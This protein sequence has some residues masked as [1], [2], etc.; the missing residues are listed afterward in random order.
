MGSYRDSI[1]GIG[2]IVKGSS[3]GQTGVGKTKNGRT[4]IVPSGG[5][6]EQEE[7]DYTLMGAIENADNEK[8]RQSEQKEALENLTKAVKA[9]PKGERAKAAREFIGENSP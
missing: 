6:L 9:A 5:I 3:K 7:V 2:I 1:S 4:I 8:P